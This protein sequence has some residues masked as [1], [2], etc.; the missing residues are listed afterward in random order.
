MFVAATMP[1]GEGKTVAGDLA[2]LFPDLLWLSGSSLH[3]AQRQVAHTWLP[4]TEDT[5]RSAL[6][7]RAFTATPNAFAT[8]A[9]LSLLKR[10][11]HLSQV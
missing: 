1:S 10:H 7:A 11:S 9:S 5:W 2:R 4:V 6:Q 3:E 8:C